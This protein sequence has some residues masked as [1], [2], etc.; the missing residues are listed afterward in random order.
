MTRIVGARIYH[1]VPFMKKEIAK[2]I[3]GAR[4]DSGE[5][6]W[7]WPVSCKDKIVALFPETRR[8]LDTVKVVPLTRSEPVSRQVMT[9][10][11]SDVHL[12][13]YSFKGMAPFS[14]QVEAVKLIIKYK[15]F[16]LFH[17]MGLGKTAS[18]IWAMDWLRAAGAFK[19]ALVV[20][21]KTLMLNWMREVEMC[22]T[23]SSTLLDGSRAQRIKLMSAETDVH[24]IN[25]DGFSIL[26]EHG[27]DQYDFVVLDE[28]QYI[29]SPDARRTKFIVKAFQ[30]RNIYK[31]L[32]TGTP[33][34]QNL[35]DM[36]TQF[37]FLNPKFF[38]QGSYYSFRGRYA[39]MGGYGGYE[40][41]DFKNVNEA[42]EIIAEHSSQKK[43]DDVLDL[44]VKMSQQF[45]LEMPDKMKSQYN[46]MKRDMTM[47]FSDGGEM[48]EVN[49]SVVLAKLLRLQE[50]LAGAYL[51]EDENPKAEALAEIV[52]NA[53]GP[54]VVFAHFRK[55]IAV[56]EGVMQKAK[57]PY[58]MIHGDI[59]DREDQVR[60]FQSGDTKVFIGSLSAAS[61]GITLTAASTMVYFE[62][63]FKLTD[64]IQ[65]EARIHRIGQKNACQYI[66]LVYKDTYDE[67]II[68]AIMRKADIAEG[69]VKSF[70]KM[71]IGGEAA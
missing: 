56:I 27:W 69:L 3:P 36:Y 71:N 40:V 48:K 24:I 45:V 41:I 6:Q 18:T 16:A 28:S 34:T 54:I 5:K 2:R 11:I 67:D 62:N 53:S 1:D 35:L 29:K 14:H 68:A 37:R 57:I 59:T 70:T 46:S 49:A 63:N 38:N 60:K 44:P 50:I 51:G 15:Q 30:D 12:G 55:S 10:S 66:D 58:S 39:V 42:K 7:S 13:A 64:R 9:P 33:V 26:N 8:I 52:N 21:P 31:V 43:K 22:S 19:R 4:F 32:L 47:E 25:Y 20:C 61:V 65:S 17:E 23:L